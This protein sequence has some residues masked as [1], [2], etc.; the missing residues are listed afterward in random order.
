[1]PTISL[2]YGILIQMFWRDHPPPH[3]H[4]RYA[5][6]KAQIDIQTLDIIEGH[7]PRTALAL[8]REW[9]EQHRAE[10]MENWTLCAQ[11]Q[12]PQKISPLP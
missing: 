11:N 3:F 9:G 4:A 12:P 5:G 1:M 2:F 8:V 10:L 6:F 7:L